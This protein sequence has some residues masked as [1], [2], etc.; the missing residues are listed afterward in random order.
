MERKAIKYTC[1]GMRRD[2]SEGKHPSEFYY[3][4]KNIR[5]IT[6]DEVITG[7]IAFEKGNRLKIRI[8]AVSIDQSKNL[9]IPSGYEPLSYKRGNEIDAQIDAGLLPVSTH[10]GE[11]QI[12]GNAV[13]KENLILFTTTETGMDCIWD[14]NLKDQGI[15]LLYMRHLDFS[16]EHPIQ[17]VYNY[18]NEKIQ[19]VYWVDGQNQIRFVNITHSIKNGDL[20]ELINV[21]SNTIDFVGNFDMSQPLIREVVS[22]GGHTAGR[23]QYA[24]VLYRLNASQTKLSPFSEMVSLNKFAN[25]GGGDINEVVASTPVIDIK[26]LDPEY[27]HIKVYAIKYT[28]YNQ[29]P[30]INMISDEEIS[31]S[32]EVTLFDDGNTLEEISLEQFLFLGSDPIVPRHIETKDN[33]L[34]SGNVKEKNFDVDLDTRAYSF[35]SGTS[36]TKVYDNI[37]SEL[38]SKNIATTVSVSNDFH[39]VKKHDA[40]NLDYSKYKYLPNST[41]QLGGEGKYVKYELIQ[42]SMY[43]HKDNM[44]FKDNEVYRIGLIFYNRLGQMSLPKWM[45][46]FRA[47]EGNLEG[48][49]T[50]LKVT[51]KPAFYDWLNTSANFK[52]ED[53]KPV[54]YKVIRANRTLRD[55]TIISQ[56]MLSTMMSN[57]RGKKQ[58]DINTLSDSPKRDKWRNAEKMPSLIRIFD[59][60]YRQSRGMKDGRTLCYTNSGTHKG[61]GV[62]REVNWASSQDQN[63]VADT[64]QFN[65]LMQMHSPDVLFGDVSI[66]AGVSLRIKGLAKHKQ[67][68]YWGREINPNNEIV[69]IEAKVTGGLTPN[70]SGASVQSITGTSNQLA[71]YGIFGPGQDNADDKVDFHQFYRDF[72]GELLKGTLAES[73]RRIPVYGVPM[74]V[75][76]GQGI[77][78]YNGDGDYRFLNSLQAMLADGGDEHNHNSRPTESVNTYGARC[79]TFVLGDQKPGVDGKIPLEKVYQRLNITEPNSVVMA[80]FVKSDFEIYT[81]NI[82]GGNSYEAKKRTEYIE[83]GPYNKVET[84]NV[85]ILSPGDTY[86]G[87]FRFARLAKTDTK[88]VAPGTQQ[89]TEIVEVRVE[90]NV[91]LH[92]RHDISLNGWDS[93]WQPKDEEYHKYNRVYSQQ[94]NLRQ[95]QDLDYKFKEINRFEGRIMASKI[96]TPGEFIDNWTDTLVNESLDLNGKYGSLNALCSFNDELYAFQDNAM[97]ILAIN[98]RVQTQGDDGISIELGTGRVLHDY[99]YITTSSG[100]LN[101]WGVIVTTN[102]IYYIDALNKALMRFTGQGLEGLS[103]TRGFH[104]YLRDNLDIDSVRKDNIFIGSGV[105]LG[106][107]IVNNDVY[108]TSKGSSGVWTLCFNEKLGQ[109]T[110]FYDYDS[111][112]YIYARDKMLTLNPNA[113]NELYQ[114]HDGEY[115]SFY[116]I[117]KESKLVLVANPEPDHECIFTNLEYK[118]VAQ[119]ENKQEQRYTWERIRVHNEFQDTGVKTLG[120]HNLR[121]LN[122]KYRV[123]IPRNKNSTDRIRNNWAFIELAGDNKNRFF[124]LNQDIIV[125]YTTNYIVIR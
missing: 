29:I 73:S 28:S 115:N 119:D 122:R 121:K 49:H 59:N 46:D 33:I 118:S 19:K 3:E 27:T 63:G 111:P 114:M 78:T 89:L 55:R 83:I 31:P 80:E 18:E 1:Q 116:K 123:A 23:I 64:F 60:T 77:T 51:L 47:P 50:K 87:N 42:H 26:D 108:F 68:Y 76:R 92:N 44:F 43:T 14:I 71:N 125:H 25:Q 54:G 11:H 32:R 93:R 70:D 74:V 37:K 15:K 102:G 7:G 84:D 61:K 17:A 65:T 39:L 75:E 113:F 2:V 97:A 10:S 98:P 36:Q 99:K 124:Y 58:G 90:S 120:N 52:S 24:Y 101:K 81:G 62:D 22:G 41:T 12:I 117:D 38:E 9:I 57:Y 40:I 21:D 91:A 67:T 85:E 106:Y 53:E 13:G 30:S 82:Y 45:A 107:D 69:N 94:P 6:T 96:K 112:I 56:G 8:P 109:F 79:I 72:S 86:V 95:Q 16:I 66:N 104:K 35:A 34:F 48:N 88:V 100:S 4:G 103:S 5:L 110:S 105:S 20:Q